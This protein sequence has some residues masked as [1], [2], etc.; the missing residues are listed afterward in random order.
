MA[1]PGIVLALSL[2]VAPA[3]PATRMPIMSI[4]FLEDALEVDPDDPS[5]T[6]GG[7]NAAVW[8]QTQEMV[9]IRGCRDGVLEVV[10]AWATDHKLAVV[11]WETAPA[12][13]LRYYRDPKSGAVL[14][15]TYW[16][17]AEPKRARATVNRLH[18]DGSAS[19]PEFDPALNEALGLGKL[20][21]RLAAAMECGT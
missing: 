3:N 16:V 12:F 7:I 17:R 19:A 14:E 4:G 9:T 13:A 5:G 20:A 15:V 8:L 18:L 2:I 1:T 21:E 10:D 6:G 11:D